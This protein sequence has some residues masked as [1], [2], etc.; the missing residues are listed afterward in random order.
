MRINKTYSIN[1]EVVKEFEKSVPEGKRARV[2]DVL[3]VKYLIDEGEDSNNKSG[4]NT[5]DTSESLN[6]EDNDE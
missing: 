4:D 5:P 2:I 3:M 6:T 1:S